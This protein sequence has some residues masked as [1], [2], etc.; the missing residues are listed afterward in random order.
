MTTSRR[1][2]KGIWKKNKKH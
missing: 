2:L 1:K